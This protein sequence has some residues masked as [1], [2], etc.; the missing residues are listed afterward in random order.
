MTTLAT[1]DEVKN[2]TLADTIKELEKMHETNVHAYNYFQSKAGLRASEKAM[3]LS[4]YRMQISALLDAI[5]RLK[6]D[7]TC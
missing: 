6:N 4:K 3:T 5:T 7:Q 1:G 2:W